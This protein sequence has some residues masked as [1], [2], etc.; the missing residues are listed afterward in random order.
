MVVGKTSPSISM[1]DVFSKY[2]EV[3]VLSCYFNIHTL[4]CCINSPLR[5]DHN[6]SFS[7]YLN[8]E[9]RVRYIDFATDDHGS[10]MDLLC[11]YWQCSFMQALNRIY[12]DLIEKSSVNIKPKTVRTFTRQERDH[13]SKLEVKIR[14]WQSY[15]YEY[16]GSY[17]VSPQWLAYAEVY[18][19]SHKIITKTD[20]DT[21]EKHRY[22]FLADEYAYCFVNRKEGRLSL[23]IYQPYNTKGFK[24]CSKADAS[25]IDLWTKIPEYGNK[26]IIAS[27][28]KDALCIS[29]NLNIPALS[30]Q[31]EGYPMSDTAVKELKRRYKKVFISFDVDEPGKKDAIKLAESTGF[32]NIVPN[33]GKCKDFS[34][35]FKMYGKDWFIKNVTP[36]FE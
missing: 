32:E 13:L 15:D 22:V 23:K 4:P 12:N 6:P 25:V 11:Q 30:L 35:A 10:L 36:L 27:S 3:D 9:N 19:V 1:T 2:S 14:P 26:V 28:V 21:G 18:P 33:L 34:D 5:K 24:W 7:L 31:G 8:K 16:W 20:K 17:G 29:C